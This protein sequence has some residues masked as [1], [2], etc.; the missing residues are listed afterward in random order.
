M[1]ILNRNFFI[2][3][4]AAVVGI[5]LVLIVGFFILARVFGSAAGLEGMLG[6]PPLPGAIEGEMD[7]GWSV[8]GLD[9][10][11]LSMADTKGKVVFVNVWATWCP[12]CRVEMP[13]IQRLCD[14]IKGEDIAFVLVS[15]EGAETL[16]DFVET[17]GFSMPVYTLVG[18]MPR[19][20]QTRGIPTTFI[21]SPDGKIVLKHVGAA[22]WDDG[23]VVEFI[24]GL[25]QEQAAA[26]EI[27]QYEGNVDAVVDAIKAVHKAEA[28][29]NAVLLE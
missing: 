3:C 6:A 18:D 11:E 16:R 12:P 26:D 7:Y 15:R 23:T 17:Q 9:G 19:V 10:D 4:A 29:A 21:I 28:E 20:L 27:P 13:S 2:G 1:T 24:R 22:Q 5:I 8:R 25:L 14:T